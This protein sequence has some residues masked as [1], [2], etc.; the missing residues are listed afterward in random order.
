MTASSS[1]IEA[2][3]DSVA[4]AFKREL[5]RLKMRIAEERTITTG[6]DLRMF[7]AP[8]M[9]PPMRY[10][11]VDSGG[12]WI[13]LLPNDAFGDGWNSIA[14]VLSGRL[15]TRA[16][17]ICGGPEA[18]GGAQLFIFRSGETQRSIQCFLDGKRWFFH[19]TG[20]PLPFED[21]SRYRLARK[22][23]RFDPQLVRTY[24]A[25]LGVPYPIDQSSVRRAVGVSQ[26]FDQVRGGKDAICVLEGFHETVK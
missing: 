9:K 24:A 20:D 22:K 14:Q 2:P 1:Y 18:T 5:I 13:G 7:L 12:P 26:D 15:N 17:F 11:L 23:D 19:Q 3:F 10:A 21:V 6:N 16:T 4:S 8:L 25:Q